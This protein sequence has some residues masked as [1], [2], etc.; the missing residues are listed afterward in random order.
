MSD[1]MADL[2]AHLPDYLGNHLL[3]TMTALAV[4]IVI[5]V[6]LGIIATRRPRL[7]EA[8]LGIAGVLQTI[9]SLALLVL[10]VPLLGGLIGFI[11][12]LI[13][14]TL[15]SFLPILANTVLGIK[16]VDPSLVEA[17]R[18]LG[19]SDGQLL[20]RVQLPLALPVI[21]GGIRT[22]TVMAVGTATLATPVGG[23]SL[24]NYIFAGLEMND[25]NAIIFGCVFAAL[26]AVGMDQLV[27]LLEVAARR[28]SR[29]LALISA[30]GLLAVL[31]I[32]LNGPLR[33]LWSP[34]GAVIASSAFSE[35][36]ILSELMKSKLEAAGFRADQRSNMGGSIRFLALGH[37]QIDCSVTYT[38]DVWT[39]VMHRKDLAP[40]REKAI[41]EISRYL[42]E[43][44]GAVCLGSL[45]FE[46]AYALAMR[47]QDAER[48]HIYT[49]ED[50]AHHAPQLTIGAD[51]EF[52]HRSEWSRLQELYGLKFQAERPMNSSLMYAAVAKGTSVNVICAYSTDG[53]ILEND[54]VL[55]EDT[56]HAFP[57]YDALLV[58]SGKAAAD[59]KLVSALRPLVQSIPMEAMRKANKRVDVDGGSP[60]EAATELLRMMVPR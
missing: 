53:H 31:A 10:M 5:S 29:R 58:L 3:L 12:A 59:P 17:A 46:N 22:A 20:R 16:G 23:L 48:L 40:K 52:F 25:T 14:L 41:E 6:P 44:Y 33:S 18:G 19:M 50:L 57:P 4:A 8:L 42:H 24:G 43:E 32:G 34:P 38:G 21:V 27:R 15:Y 36:Y 2:L 35:Q 7:A 28:R 11:P 45:G 47:R 51:M 13:A 56:K 37:N 39:T 30:A 60:R 26:L 9:P 54:L 1:S 49:I 55:L